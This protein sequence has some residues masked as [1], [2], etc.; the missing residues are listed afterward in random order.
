MVVG[1]RRCELDDAAVQS[2]EIFDSRT[3]LATRQNILTIWSEL[4][5]ERVKLSQKKTC[6][7]T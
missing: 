5:N 6:H 2:P 4:V 3:A 7:R 1:C